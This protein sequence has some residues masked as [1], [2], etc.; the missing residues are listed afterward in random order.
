[1]QEAE[2]ARDSLA[3]QLHDERQ[4]RARMANLADD[5]RAELDAVS[6]IAKQ[7]GDSLKREVDSKDAENTTLH[8][9]MLQEK[10]R[11]AALEDNIRCARHNWHR[12]HVHAD[13]V[14]SCDAHHG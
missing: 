7:E 1:M 12:G 9:R 13:T 10:A 11:G 6:Q 3:Q 2:R 8:Q 4:E 14:C 5:T